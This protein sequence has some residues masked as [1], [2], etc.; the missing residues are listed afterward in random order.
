MSLVITGNTRRPEMRAKLVEYVRHISRSCP[1]EITEVR[2]AETALKKLEADRSAT[3]L[4]LD[5]V[6]RSIDSNSP[7][8]WLRELPHHDPRALAFIFVNPR[9]FPEYFPIRLPP[10]P[11]PR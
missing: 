1:I 10:E 8:K 9:C 11:S 4:L 2:D 5:A 7:A 3:V 6:G